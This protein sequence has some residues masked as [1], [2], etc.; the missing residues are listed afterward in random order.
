M[1]IYDLKLCMEWH[2]ICVFMHIFKSFCYPT[3]FK[4]NDIEKK[5]NTSIPS[6][7]NASNPVLNTQSKPVQT[8]W[9]HKR[10]VCCELQQT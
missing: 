8:L 5:F 9:F 6:F 3:K 4:I 2:I 7:P 1:N 10:H